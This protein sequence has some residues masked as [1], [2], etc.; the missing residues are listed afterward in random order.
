VSAIRL[1]TQKD[2]ENFLRVLTEES[3]LK[4]RKSIAE[5]SAQQ[6]QSDMIKHIK[7]SKSDLSEEDPEK[8]PPAAPTPAPAAEPKPAPAPAAELEPEVKPNKPNE[9]PASKPEPSSELNPTLDSLIRAIKEI[10]SGFGSGDSTVEQELTSYFDRLDDAERVSLIVMMR[11]LG[12]IMRR[13]VQGASAP[14]PGQYNVIMSMKPGEKAQGSEPAA[15][16]PRTAGEAPPSEEDTSPPIKVGQPV[17]ETY[18]AR[19]RDLLSR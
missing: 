1:K 19:I 9:P 10:R 7:Q 18:R 4:A 6:R 14:A 2:L 15:Q 3:V 17:S 13:E 12:D 16:K 8:T 11:S 5:P